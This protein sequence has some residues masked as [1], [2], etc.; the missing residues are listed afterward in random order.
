MLLLRLFA[1]VSI[2][3]PTVCAPSRYVEVVREPPGCD[4]MF[5]EA[6]VAPD[7]H[8]IVYSIG[9][10]P[11]GT[12]EGEYTAVY[13]RISADGGPATEIARGGQVSLEQSLSADGRLVYPVAS[14]AEGRREIYSMPTA[15]SLAGAVRLGPPGGSFY[16]Y[17]LQPG[18]WVVYRVGDGFWEELPL[19]IVPAA[20]P[21]EAAQPLTHDD[22]APA[23]YAVSSDG[24]TLGYV[25]R[26]APPALYLRDLAGGGPFRRVE[27]PAGV[28]WQNGVL[29]FTPDGSQAL[30]T[31]PVMNDPGSV[32]FHLWRVAVAG[33]DPV[34]IDPPGSSVGSFYVAPDS[35]HVAFFRTAYPHGGWPDL[36]IAAL[37]APSGESSL[38]HEA[39]E[40]NSPWPWFSP[41]GSRI[42]TFVHGEEGANHLY[43]E[44]VELAAG[45][46][47]SPTLHITMP[48]DVSLYAQ[49]SPDSRLIAFQPRDL[50]GVAEGL[51]VLPVDGP[52]TAG[53]ELPIAGDWRFTPDSRRIVYMGSAFVNLEEGVAFFSLPVDGSAPPYELTAGLPPEVWPAGGILWR[54]LPDGRVLLSAETGAWVLP[55]PGE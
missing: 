21:A 35:R 5:F 38:L 40:I 47:I 8:T 39:G 43:V 51:R 41:D 15:G 44:D 33:G 26:E 24:R 12:C 1:L 32:P 4:R 53:V 19:R 2:S 9:E 22:R 25:T 37:D 30:L 14:D 42:A 52:E 55:V 34:R 54:L 10:L 27:L 28:G 7:G 18:S 48:L 50:R 29:E 17:D 20:G 45:G 13:Y 49:F 11:A 36:Y 23:R 46:L 3:L 6:A 16:G 31:L